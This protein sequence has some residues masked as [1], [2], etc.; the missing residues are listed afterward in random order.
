MAGNVVPVRPPD[1]P[2]GRRFPNGAAWSAYL[3]LGCVTLALFWRVTGF[4]F[5]NFDDGE[6]IVDNAFLK[7]DF[8][9]Q[10]IVWAFTT[11]RGGNWHPLTWLSHMLDYKL[12]GLAA[13][14]HHL[15]NVVLHIANSLL[16]LRVLRGLTGAFWRSALVA[17]LFALHPLHVESVAWVSERKDT[18]STLFLILALAA[19]LRY[20]Q[21]RSPG[22]YLLVILAAAL[23]LL[24]KPTVVT[25]PLVLLLLDFWPL[26]RLRPGPGGEAVGGLIKEKIPLLA[27]AA[28]TAG[29][30][31]YAPVKL[32]ALMPLNLIPLTERVGNGIISSARYLLLTVWPA[33]LTALYP[34]PE[35]LSRSRVILSLAAL[36]ALTVLAA[37]TVRERPAVAMGWL[38]YLLVLLPMIGIVQ[39]GPQVMADRYTYVAL[40]GIFVAAVWGMPSPRPGQSIRTALWALGVV[41]ALGGCLLVSWR[42]IGT[43][44]D[45]RTLFQRATA[46]TADNYYAYVYLGAAL[47]GEGRFEEAIAQVRRARDISP[48]FPLA[49]S[50]LGA[51]LAKM[52]RWEEAVTHFRDAIRLGTGS[53]G[54]HLDLGRALIRIRHVREG[55]TH[56]REALRLD[57][58]SEE[59]YREIAAAL[60]A[61]GQPDAATDSYRKLLELNP[62]SGE[63]H[64]GLGLSAA[65]AGRTREAIA[66]FSRA[67]Q[68]M[69]QSAAAQYNLALA[70][71]RT[72]SQELA[73]ERYT[74]ALAIDPDNAD[75]HNNLG[76]I[77]AG[78]GR[79]DEAVGH[80][81]QSL[82]IDPRH[83]E[84]HF[85]LGLALVRQG[86]VK[87]AA[88]SFQT[89]LDLRPDHA[90]ARNQLRLLSGTQR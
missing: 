27:L 47:A 85:N 74:L 64:F 6:Y 80:F 18:L 32:Q 50:T 53:A 52:D 16:L 20:V 36:A 26:G 69:P 60:S 72:G 62:D 2:A 63:A 19:Y 76:S 42:Q 57:P 51:I 48:A 28:L 1:G 55:L 59:A 90:P 86:D 10:G 4:S 56:L 66:H 3:C 25:L 54:A 39:V 34:Y 71:E 46:V 5:V 14:R 8:I 79:L 89:V 13:G 43:W 83:V 77:L 88:A 22:G 29:F 65:Q 45:S 41:V 11:F 49:H 17:A 84:A 9:P 24:S 12:F 70:F 87:G 21:R 37:R 23:G 61:D 78:L 33:G 75:A 35:T 31:L 73:L 38:W 15:V 40:I 30:T 58:G 82:R 67:A 7:R 68:I 81:R 44:H